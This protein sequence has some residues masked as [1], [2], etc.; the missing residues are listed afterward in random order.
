MKWYKAV[1]SIL[2]VFGLIDWFL[3][4]ILFRMFGFVYPFP[5]LNGIIDFL[6]ILIGIYVYTYKPKTKGVD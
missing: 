6:L 4:F 1:G 3:P 2:I 5:S